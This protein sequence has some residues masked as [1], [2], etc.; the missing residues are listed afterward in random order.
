MSKNRSM[1]LMAG[2]M[3]VVI[4]AGLAGNCGYQRSVIT[5]KA[6]EVDTEE[7]QEV[8]EHALD[9]EKD[10]EGEGTDKAQG[11]SKEESVYVKADPAGN[12][13]STTVTEWLK[14]PGTGTLGDISELEDIKNIKGEETYKESGDTGLDWQ[15]E[16]DDIYY[17]GTTE[18]ELPVGVKISYK[19]DGKEISAEDLQGKDGKVE[20]HIQY[21]NNSKSV[22]DVNGESVEMFTPFTMITAMMLPADEYQNIEI[23]NGKVI[24]DAEKEI[25]VG[26]GFPGLNENLK[27]EN[28]DFELPEDV[29]ITADVKNASVGPTITVASTEFLQDLDL[30]NIDDFDDLSDSIG[31]LKDA[32]NQL[33]DGSKA[34]AEGAGQLADGAGTLADGTGTLAE[35]INTLNSSSGELISGVSSLRDGIGSYTEGIDALAKG[36]A[37]DSELMAGVSGLSNLTAGVSKGASVV[38]DTLKKVKSATEQGVIDAEALNTSLSKLETAVD[39]IGYNVE[40][41]KT[42]S[43]ADVLDESGLCEE[44]RNLG[45][46]EEQ[47][48]GI[49]SAVNG[50]ISRQVNI[51]GNDV[52]VSIAGIEGDTGIKA[53]LGEVSS[54]AAAVATDIGTAD[55]VIGALQT[56]VDDPD[57]TKGLVASSAYA[58]QLTGAVGDGIGQV[59]AGVDQ[60]KNYNS[61]LTGGAA[62]LLEGGSQLTSGVGQFAEGANALNSGAGAL[63]EGAGALADGNQALAEGMAAYKTEAIDHLTDL[64]DGD[65]AGA[66]DRLRAMSE[67]GKEYK[68]FAGIS[69]EMSGSTKFIIET[70]GVSE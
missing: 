48:S 38:S 37:N 53:V 46:T 56:S 25:V 35:G 23:D 15:A 2:A 12:V 26:L 68:S 40:G 5:A 4:A 61:V 69:S 55:S 19:L 54:N 66:V 63:V 60:L 11:T 27:L 30:D 34:A 58:V 22:A 59:K 43:S 8:A 17:Q 52:S 9:T 24:S 67:L 45:Y 28:V 32:T 57:I 31:E 64:F 70:E 16:G 3:A 49:I 14:N 47:I 50:H 51:D 10:Q 6:A 65:I 1:K 62:Q 21:T 39:N 44:L 36:M 18:K 33:V 7:L 41:T 20:I 42:I 13:K 29:T